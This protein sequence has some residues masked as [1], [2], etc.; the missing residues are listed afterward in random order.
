MHFEFAEEDAI[1]DL[2]T[3]IQ[4]GAPGPAFD[5]LARFVGDQENAVEIR[6][7]IAGARTRRR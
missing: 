7:R 5:A 3:A 4:A 1:N 6:E 2:V